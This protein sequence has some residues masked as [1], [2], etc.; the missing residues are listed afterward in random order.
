MTWVMQVP[1]PTTHLERPNS[2]MWRWHFGQSLEMFRVDRSPPRKMTI[3]YLYGVTGYKM[4]ILMCPWQKCQQL[5][6]IIATWQKHRQPWCLHDGFWGFPTVRG[7]LIPGNWK[8]PKGMLELE[9]HRAPPFL[10]AIFQ[11]AKHPERGFRMPPTLES[12]FSAKSDQYDKANATKS[13]QPAGSC[14]FFQLWMVDD[15]VYLTIALVASKK[16][17]SRKTARLQMGL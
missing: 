14:F 17:P 13:S 6:Y 16:T 2:K 9:Q 11:W 5:R 3:F 1:A 7:E 12:F 10:W 4:S 8:G 15:W